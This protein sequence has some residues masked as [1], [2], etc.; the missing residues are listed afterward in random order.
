MVSAGACL[1]LRERVFAVVFSESAKE[2]SGS[3][4][5]SSAVE[6]SLLKSSMLNERM[7]WPWVLVSSS[8]GVLWALGAGR[9]CCMVG[10][11]WQR[12]GGGQWR[13]RAHIRRK[14]GRGRKHGFV[15][16][17][18]VCS[19]IAAFVCGSR[20]F[21]ERQPIRRKSLCRYYPIIGS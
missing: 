5:M 9:S 17:T 6:T 18:G 14:V 1:L 7:R 16:N 12:E 15:R 19:R 11:G 4:C 21:L 2:E 13:R 8:V 20:L 10:G 3:L